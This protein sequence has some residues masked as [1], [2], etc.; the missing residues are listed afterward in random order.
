MT[1]KAKPRGK[2][3]KKGTDTR[4]NAGGRPRIPSDVRVALIGM[5]PH[6]VERLRKII[7][8]G[9]DDALALK[10]S[11]VILDRVCGQNADIG[12]IRELRDHEFQTLTNHIAR[13][14]SEAEVEQSIDNI[15]DAATAAETPA[16]A[17]CN[18][19]TSI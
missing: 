15:M 16:T 10:A 1:T 11:Q 19:E 4:R 6:A 17:E 3:F 5:W 8:E 18:A 12:Y 14:L 9:K 13:E 7:V 2:P